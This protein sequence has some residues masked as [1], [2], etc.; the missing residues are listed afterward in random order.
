MKSVLLHRRRGLSATRSS[1]LPKRERIRRLAGLGLSKH[2]DEQLERE[3]LAVVERFRNWTNRDCACA[4]TAWRNGERH[5]YQGADYLIGIE[6]AHVTESRGHF[7]PDFGASLP[8]CSLLHQESHRDPDFWA[9]RDL[10]PVVLA[11]LHAIRFFAAHPEDADW[12]IGN[13]VDGDV[14]ALAQAGKA[15]R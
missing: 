9:K 1:G 5:T 12:V 10:D 11:R 7:A 2:E 13:A 3:A 15:E 8:L 14:I 4:V 6:W